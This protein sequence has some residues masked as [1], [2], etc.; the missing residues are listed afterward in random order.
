MQR[1]KE[2]EKKKKKPVKFASDN[3]RIQPTFLT[4]RTETG[5]TKI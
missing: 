1:E 3:T 4:F 2:R 5:T